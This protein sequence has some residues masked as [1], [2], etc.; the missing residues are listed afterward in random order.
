MHILWYRSRERWN[1]D[2]DMMPQDE[3]PLLPT[4][5]FTIY[6]QH[7]WRPQ[8]SVHC[9]RLP[10]RR[11]LWHSKSERL[12]NHAGAAP[13]LCPSIALRLA[14]RSSSCIKLSTG[15]YLPRL[16]LDQPWPLPPPPRG[17][18]DYL[19]ELCRLCDQRVC[20]CVCVCLRVCVYVCV[21]SRLPLRRL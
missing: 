20:V 4:I 2:I 16:A 6:L 12:P 7:F 11:L 8:C 19:L 1:K 13:G 21:C 5:Q 14:P 17:L 10:Y 15:H 9:S 18:S 3:C